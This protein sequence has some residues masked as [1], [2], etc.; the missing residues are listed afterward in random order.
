MKLNYS[1]KSD[2]IATNKSLN[3]DWGVEP[4]SSDNETDI[5]PL[6]EPAI[7][8]CFVSFDINIIS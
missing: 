5:L 6:D 2:F 3:A 8:K 1:I 4:Q 7:F